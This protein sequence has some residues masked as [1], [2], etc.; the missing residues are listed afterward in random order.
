MTAVTSM[1]R[2][3]YFGVEKDNLANLLSDGCVAARCCVQV[4]FR[5]LY[6][7]CIKKSQQKVSLINSFVWFELIFQFLKFFFGH[8]N[9]LSLGNFL[10]TLVLHNPCN[11]VH[12]G[13]VTLINESFI[14]WRLPQ[15]VWYQKRGE[16]NY[17]K[18]KSFSFPSTRVQ[19]VLCF[20]TCSGVSLMNQTFPFYF[21]DIPDGW[22]IFTML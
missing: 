19:S 9:L 18:K 10:R 5:Y 20:L 22:D 17:K 3:S 2:Y 1:L 21:Q 11:E 15:R 13:T 14:N 16:F 7:S 4:C 6:S 12:K 8:A